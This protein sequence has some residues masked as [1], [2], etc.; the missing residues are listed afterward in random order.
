MTWSEMNNSFMQKSKYIY[1]MPIHGT[2]IL[3]YTAVNKSGK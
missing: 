2:G 1:K 3:S